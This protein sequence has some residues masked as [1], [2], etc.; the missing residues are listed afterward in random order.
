MTIDEA[1]K[2]A[3]KVAEEQTKLCKRY[4]DASGYSRSHNEAIRT[5]DAKRC[6]KCAEEHLQIAEWF[7]EL[8][9]LREQTIWVPI[10]ERLPT[11]KE[12]IANN[13]LFIVSDGNRTYAEYFDVYDSMKYFGEPTMN[14]FRI[15]RCVVA[16][17]PLPEPYQEESEERI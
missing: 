14:G 12:Y 1:I 2:H 13:G 5:T 6:E 4:D 9:Q 11:K 7:K 16:W 10:S 8:K 17:M 15:D 3:E